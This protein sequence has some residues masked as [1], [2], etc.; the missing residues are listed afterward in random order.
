MVMRTRETKSARESTRLHGFLSTANY[1][2]HPV[3]P[4][5]LTVEPRPKDH[6]D[7]IYRIGHDLHDVSNNV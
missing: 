2:F 6:L 3:N 5:K 7:R 1:K 4:V